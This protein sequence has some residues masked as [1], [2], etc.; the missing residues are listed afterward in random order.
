MAGL[1]D[2]RVG[3]P[4]RLFSPLLLEPT[5]G[6]VC[7]LDGVSTALDVVTSSFDIIWFCCWRGG[8]DSTKKPAIGPSQSRGFMAHPLPSTL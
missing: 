3:N 6:A 1:G 7:F 2:V 5:S 8:I 4:Y